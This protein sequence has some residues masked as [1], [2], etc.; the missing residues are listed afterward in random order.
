MLM[1]RSAALLLVCL[2]TSCAKA[3]A[4]AS[5]PG[6]KRSAQAWAGKLRLEI[7][8]K[9]A[10][11]PFRSEMPVQVSLINDSAR[12]VWVNRRLA[13][14]DASVG[15]GFEVAFRIVDWKGETHEYGCP[16]EFD[17]P[18]PTEF[19]WLPAGTA[20]RETLTLRNCY[21]LRQYG[22]YEIVATYRDRSIHPTPSPKGDLPYRKELVSNRAKFE[23]LAP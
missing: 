3:P 19:G 20:M 22:T 9:Q 13:E 12:D 1:K 21:D 11:L 2:A 17:E 16:T 6:Q 23:Y 8:V 18:S 5:P 7:A 4:G 10:R 15:G 14:G